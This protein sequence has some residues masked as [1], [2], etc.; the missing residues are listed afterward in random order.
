M[1]SILIIS[2]LN[3]VLM[4]GALSAW[5]RKHSCSYD[6]CPFKDITRFEKGCGNCDQGTDCWALDSLHIEF[7]YMEYDELEQELFK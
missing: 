4:A 1:K 6:L 5:P 3:I 7:P 2:L